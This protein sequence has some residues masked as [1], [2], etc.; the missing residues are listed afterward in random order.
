MRTSGSTA[1]L[2]PEIESLKMIAPG[3]KRSIVD[4]SQSLLRK[5]PLKHEARL[6]IYEMPP[7]AVGV[8]IKMFFN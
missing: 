2:S 7:P 3:A 6:Y 8:G 4:C 1:D 5:R